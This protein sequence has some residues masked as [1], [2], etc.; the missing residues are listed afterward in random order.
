MP[1]TL[2]GS[3]VKRLRG[4]VGVTQADL[5]RHLGYTRAAISRW[6]RREGASIPRTQYGRVLDFL[7]GRYDVAEGQRTQI[8][9]LRTVS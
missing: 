3:D 4:T 1:F 8:E 7:K 6:E 2:T 5:A 9:R